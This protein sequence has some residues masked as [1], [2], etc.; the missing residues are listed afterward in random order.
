MAELYQLTFAD[1]KSY[2]GIAKTSAAKRFK[3]HQ[4]NAKRGKFQSA[5]Y[6]AWRT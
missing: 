1:G 3:R 6:I 5:K 2:I 4:Y